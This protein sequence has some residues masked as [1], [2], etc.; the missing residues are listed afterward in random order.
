ML[1][2]SY[3]D[4]DCGI[5]RALEQ[6]GER[7][8][9]LIVRDALF[10]RSTRFSEFQ[11]TLAIASNVLSSRLEHLVATQLFEA[12]DEPEGRRY[13]PTQRAWDLVP[14]LIAATDWGEKWGRPGPIDYVERATGDAVELQL[15][16]ADSG[17]PVAP[18]NIAVRLRAEPGARSTG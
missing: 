4:Q 13:F 1:G 18:E 7:W 12:R 11:R 8:T 5:A 15:V 10:R 6:I 9:L 2:K 3:E 16:H 14:V 17:K